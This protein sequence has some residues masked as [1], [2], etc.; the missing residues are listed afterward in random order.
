MRYANF[1]RIWQAFN[2][3]YDRSI[4]EILN[5]KDFDINLDYELQ[6]RIEEITLDLVGFDNYNEQLFTNINE[7]LAHV[8]NLTIASTQN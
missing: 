4:L 1:S 6:C 8:K 2:L 5:T 7:K 3:P